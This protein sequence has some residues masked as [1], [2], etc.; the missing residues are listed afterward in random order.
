MGNGVTNLVEA[1]DPPVREI[2]DRLRELA[3]E[4]IPEA[5]EEP[6]LSATLIGYTYKPGT[7]K[8]LVAAIAP[9]ASHV[10]LMLSTGAELTAVDT[11]GLLEGTGKK[12]RHIKFRSPADTERPG[13][14]ELLT[15]AARLT[16]RP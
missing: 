10:N 16:P 3:A 11:L 14:R 1:L 9:H 4:T 12:A 7:Y 6:D 2:V 5:V 15:E 13:V 8:H